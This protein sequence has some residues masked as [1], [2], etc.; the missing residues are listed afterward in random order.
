[1]SK[2]IAV[3]VGGTF[4]DV[5]FSDDATGRVIVAKG[6]TVPAS[7]EVGVLRLVDSALDRDDLA[8][9]D[10][11]LHG[12]TV[13]L[14]ALLQREGVAVGLI[15]TE[16]FR[17]ILEVRRSDRDDPYDLFWTQ[18]PAL[19]P[20]RLR[21]PVAERVLAD[22]SVV[23]PLVVEDVSRAY[24]VFRSEGVVSVAIALMNAYANPAHEL[25][26]EAHLRQLG[27]S[28][29][30]SMSHRMS[31]E[32]R[33]YERT[34][35]TV[36][37]A[38]VRSRVS[39]YL[40]RLDQGL[41]ERGFEGEALITRCGG[42]ALHFA[43]AESRPFETIISGPVAGVVGAAV[44][45]REHGFDRAI[46]ADVGGTSFDTCLIIDGRPHVKYEGSVE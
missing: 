35:T 6:A 36:I 20:R 9:A 11:F 19:V 37:D 13:G 26:I 41:R 8:R 40:A 22:G 29:S 38:Y 23:T 43:E 17:D 14:N 27:F 44:L 3:D 24:E 1:M 10:Y 30:I 7:P 45:A 32:Y 15:A 42:G 28:G 25:A 18:P 12:T 31:K 34:S 16:G 46:S 39:E 4:T 5:V 2:Q 33:E 21:L